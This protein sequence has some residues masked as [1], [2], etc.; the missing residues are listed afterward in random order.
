M[1]DSIWS[2]RDWYVNFLH[3][4]ISNICL[5]YDVLSHPELLYGAVDDFELDMP[6]MSRDE[7]TMGRI[8]C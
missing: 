6:G 2:Y 7:E 3:L 1:H 4:E 8:C 5:V